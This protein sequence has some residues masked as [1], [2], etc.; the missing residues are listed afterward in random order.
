MESSQIWTR[1]ENEST[2]STQSL[3]VRT[4]RIARFNS[5]ALHCVKPPACHVACITFLTA[6]YPDLWQWSVEHYHLFWEELFLYTD[7][8][9]SSPYDEVLL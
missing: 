4:A 6:S 2:T 9:H 5:A 8:L 7:I 1:S 3:L